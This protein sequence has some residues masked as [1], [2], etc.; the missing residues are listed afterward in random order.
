MKW[1]LVTSNIHKVNEIARFLDRDIGHR[2]LDL[3]EIQSVDVAEVVEAKARLAFEKLKSP[4]MV[5]DTGLSFAT[6]NGLPGALVKWFL[7]SLGAD[8]MCKM[9]DGYKSRSAFAETVIA[10]FDGEELKIFQGRID[11]HIAREPK[12]NL[13]FGWDSIFIPEGTDKTFAEMTDA[14]R[15]AHSPRTRALE[16]MLTPQT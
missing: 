16:F 1:T 3:V 4:V 15:A 5:E 6:L 11:G 7:K 10:T 2:D 12:G 9:L 13:G 8:G 14:E